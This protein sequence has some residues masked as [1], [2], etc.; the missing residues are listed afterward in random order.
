M[1]HF[2]CHEA[3]ELHLIKG[4]AGAKR[5]IGDTINTISDLDLVLLAK[6]NL[7]HVWQRGSYK[8]D[9]HF[10]LQV[11]FLP[12]LFAGL[13]DKTC[14]DAISHLFE[15][16]AS[17]LVFSNAMTLCV[18]QDLIRL[19]TTKDSLQQYMLFLNILNRLSSDAVA[20]RIA[21]PGFVRDNDSLEN[22]SVVMVKNY[23]H[24]HYQEEIYIK[25]LA[26][27]IGVEQQWLSVSFKNRT[28]NTVIDYVNQVRLGQVV[29]RLIDTE[30]PV[31]KIAEEC[32]FLNLANF[33]RQFKRTK[34]ITPFAFRKAYR[35]EAI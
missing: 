33:N 18:Y 7:P 31:A 11:Y 26:D 32:G 30:E 12:E 14:F 34:G 28:G 10:V 9:G 19:A 29:R 8:G 27:L 22:N 35:T 4:A 17:G 25:T 15:L 20:K 2:H 24:E 3:Y 16:A 6:S 21:G 1:R 23:I 5:I 13:S